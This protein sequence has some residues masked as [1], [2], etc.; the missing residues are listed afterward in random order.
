LIVSQA[1]VTKFL[2]RQNHQRAR[3]RA[4]ALDRST[5]V[6]WDEAL[7]CEENHRQAAEAL[8]GQ[9]GWSGELIGAALPTGGFAFVPAPS[10]DGTA[11][12]S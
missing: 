2:N 10:R 3:V 7:S 4:V 12:R 6:Y 9:L 1:I 8:Q 11:A 5:T